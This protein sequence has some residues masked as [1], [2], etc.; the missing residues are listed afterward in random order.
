MQHRNGG[1][2]RRETAASAG[3]WRGVATLDKGK[4]GMW[5]V[6]DAGG[7][8]LWRGTR[9]WVSRSEST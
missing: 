7:S 6:G 4:E 8:H 2:S 5:I 9:L 1:P 3:W